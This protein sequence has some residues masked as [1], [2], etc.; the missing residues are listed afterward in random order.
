MSSCRRCAPGEATPEGSCGSLCG[1]RS[2]GATECIAQEGNDMAQQSAIEWTDATHNHWLGCTHVSPGCTN[3][4]AET[5]MDKRYGRVRWGKGKPRLLT[6]A[7]NRRKPL[8]WNKACA[9]DGTRMR[10]F[11]A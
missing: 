9:V 8:L 2:D 1:L 4:Y 10:V 7:A 3:C 5:M 11:S 6:S